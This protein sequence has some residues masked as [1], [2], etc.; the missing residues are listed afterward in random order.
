MPL[1]STC[2][3]RLGSRFSLILDPI[4]KQVH[5]GALGLMCQSEAE[6]VIGLAGEGLPFQALPLSRA[7]RD[8]F[9]VD[10]FL[11]MTSVR[12][13]AYS[14]EAGVKF[15]VTLTAPFWPQ[16]EPVSLVPTYLVDFLVESFEMVRWEKPPVQAPRRGVLRF[17]VRLPASAGAAV[18]THEAGGLE[19]TY[20]V[21]ARDVFETTGPL[22]VPG[23]LR[24]IRRQSPLTGRA[25]DRLV[26][27][28]AGNKPPS[29]KRASGKA[30]RSAG[31]EAWRVQGDLLEIP[32]DVQNDEPHRSSLA[33]VGWCG[34]P[35]FERFGQAMPLKYTAIWR[36]AEAVVKYVRQHHTMLRDRSRAFDAL[37]A[38][39]PLGPDGQALWAT[40]FQSYLMNTLWAVQP[41]ASRKRHAARPNATPAAAPLG[42]SIAAEASPA[43]LSAHDRSL[44]RAADATAPAPPALPAA[45]HAAPQGVPETEWFS[46]WEGSC[47][48]NSTVDVTY[49]EAMIYFSLWPQLLEKL[50]A[51]WSQHAN[52]YA[53]E[54][55]RRARVSD[56]DKHGNPEVPFPGR[57]MEHD[58]GAG[59]SANGQSY[60]HAMPVE[61]NSNFL[62]M[63]Y[64]HAAWWD[65]AELVHQHA[66]VCADLLTY[67]LWA[68][69]TGNGFPDRGVANTIDDATPAVQYGRDNVYLGIKRLAALHAGARM[70]TATGYTALAAKCQQA[71]KK[72]VRTLKAGWLKDHWGVCLDK[73]ARGLVHNRT[74]EPLPYRTLPG[75]DAYS[76]YTTNGLLYL[77]MIDDLPAGLDKARLKQDVVHATAASMK[78]YGCGHSSLDTK[79]AWVSMNLWRDAV[80]GY[81]GLDMRENLQRYWAQ[82]LFANGPGS[83]KPN[84][85]TETSLTNNLVWYPRGAAIFGLMLALPQLVVHAAEKDVTT[86]PIVTGDWPL[87]PLI[88]WDAAGNG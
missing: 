62:L 61:E 8:F 50:F 31:A 2:L 87:L 33:M 5:Y 60:W 81:L 48:F 38:E 1:F 49:N 22:V 16:D 65:R 79:N 42:C 4:R 70:M 80:A 67:L 25:T 18:R 56:D 29:P 75:W 57:V 83:E 15:S 35:L 69:S 14:V 73:S 12:Y 3:A 9:V 68:D 45:S 24:D 32:F 84:C 47:W 36:D 71:V 27:L 52:D 88:D 78:T 23:T 77:L 11:T 34:D 37:I 20:P 58:M 6:L 40:A 7:G 41:P 85:F 13:E 51:Q 76:L 19:L 82:Q 44:D 72:A 54:Q 86:H 74:G 26:P 39:M 66:G 53:G 28:P 21:T 64:A 63:L 59:W 55:R 46:V 30:P 10:Q 43:S 17:G